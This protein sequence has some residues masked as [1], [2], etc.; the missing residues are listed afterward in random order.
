[1]SCRQNIEVLKCQGKEAGLSSI[2]EPFEPRTLWTHGFWS[3]KEQK[4]IGN[5]IKQKRGKIHPNCWNSGCCHPVGG[6]DKEEV[7]G[8]F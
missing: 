2:K 7:H 1:M 5:Y 8:V 4:S 6:Y 3:K